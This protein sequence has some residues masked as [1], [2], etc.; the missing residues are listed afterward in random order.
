MTY[1]KGMQA[2]LSLSIISA[3]KCD[4]LILDEVFDG[5]DEFFQKKISERVLR[6]I[7][8]SGA[9]MFVS[10][11]PEQ[12]RLACNRCVVIKNSA[13]AFDGSVEDGIDFYHKR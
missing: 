2:R 7:H 3:K 8:D 9:V 12:I 1:S 5:A 11:S 6:M 10:H 13:I 4:L